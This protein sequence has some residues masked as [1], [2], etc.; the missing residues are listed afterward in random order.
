V[1]W[2]PASLEDFRAYIAVRKTTPILKQ[3][4]GTLL[5]PE[6]KKDEAKFWQ[7]QSTGICALK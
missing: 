7:R 4:F 2:L 3:E 6:E 1:A 5:R